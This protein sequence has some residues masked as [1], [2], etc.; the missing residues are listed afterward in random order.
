[1]GVVVRRFRSR[2]SLHRRLLTFCPCGAKRRAF[3]FRAKG[4][5]K[6]KSIPVKE[7]LTQGHQ[8]LKAL[9]GRKMS[10]RRWSASKAS[11]EP[12]DRYPKEISSPA[13]AELERLGKVSFIYFH[14][15]GFQQGAVFFHKSDFFMMFPLVFY[16]VDDPILVLP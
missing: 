15:G 1:M 4:A 11:A 16:V 9:Q 12:A 3:S 13:R 5:K 2:C 6:A 8:G 7:I 10:N 14:A